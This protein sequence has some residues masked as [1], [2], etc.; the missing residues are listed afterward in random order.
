[1]TDIST[2]TPLKTIVSYL[3]DEVDKS[4]ADFEKCWVL[5]LRSLTQ[6][7]YSISGEPITVRLPVLGNKTVAF[8]T[9]CLSWVKIGNLNESGEIVT[10]KINNSLTTYRDLNPNRL[11]QLTADINNSIGSLALVPYYSNF[12]YNNNCYQLFGIGNGIITYG[13]CRVDERNRVV[14]LPPDFRYDSIMFEFIDIPEKN[15]DY[16]VPTCLQEAIIAFI[17][18]KLKLAPRQEYYAALIEGRRSLPKKK[19][20][21]QTLNQVI[22][23]SDSMKLRS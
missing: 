17:K 20:I 6:M 3:L 4:Y 18:W 22:R 19:V 2:Y 11:S 13:D 16:Q 5:G 8:P 21:L 7:T 1:M 23:E 15:E 12:Y 10:L 9:N 14:I